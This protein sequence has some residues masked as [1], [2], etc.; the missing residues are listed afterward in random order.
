MATE[1]LEVTFDKTVVV[2]LDRLVRAQVLPDRDLAIQDAVKEKLRRLRHAAF[3]DEC[4]KL[5]PA[6]EKALADEGFRGG[7]PWPEY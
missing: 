1:T 7:A 2:E 6:E 5:D 4:A 3:A